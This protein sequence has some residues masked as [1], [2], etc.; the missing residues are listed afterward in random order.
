MPLVQSGLIRC[1][2]SIASAE[3]ALVPKPLSC[4]TQ[5]D[6]VAADFEPG[7]ALHRLA[8]ERQLT[9]VSRGTACADMNDVPITEPTASIRLRSVW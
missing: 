2:T 6:S 4:S 3:L 5:K 8:L 9:P 1:S 7:E